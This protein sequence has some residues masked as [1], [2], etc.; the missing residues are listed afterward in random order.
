[1]N[2]NLVD[3]E[4][5]GKS[6]SDASRVGGILQFPLSLAMLLHLDDWLVVDG[7]FMILENLNKART[8]LMGIT[9]PLAIAV[10]VLEFCD[11]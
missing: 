11:R 6:V 8:L 2:S 3:K 7:V 9:L 5:T 1:M 4:N 10:T